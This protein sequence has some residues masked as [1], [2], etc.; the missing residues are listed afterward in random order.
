YLIFLS[1]NIRLICHTLNSRLIIFYFLLTFDSWSERYSNTNFI[2]N[3]FVYFGIQNPSI[4]IPDFG[5]QVR[6]QKIPFLYLIK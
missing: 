3:S 5:V 4:R 2:L 6:D 1:L